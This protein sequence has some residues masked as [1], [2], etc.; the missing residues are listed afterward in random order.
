MSTHS[1]KYRHTYPI[2]ISTFERLDRFDFKIHKVDHQECLVVD[3]DV[4][5]H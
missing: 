5:S 4:A 1:Y 2:S 3:G